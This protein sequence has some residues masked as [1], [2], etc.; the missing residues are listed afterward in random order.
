MRIAITGGKGFIGTHLAQRLVADGHQLVL[1]GRYDRGERCWPAQ[2]R[3]VKNDLSDPRLL[4]DAF[5]GCD[6]VAQ[7]W[8]QSRDRQT[9]FSACAYRGHET[10]SGRQRAGVKRSR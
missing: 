4:A 10:S 7:C 1:L 8:H 2:V 6:A 5:A 3:F 9:N